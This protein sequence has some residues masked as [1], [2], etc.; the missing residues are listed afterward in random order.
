MEFSKKII[1]VTGGL[2]ILTLIEI[3]VLSLIGADLS[4]IATQ[5]TITTGGIFGASICFYLNK[6]KIE[7]LA[8]GKVKFAFTKLKLDLK[9]KNL[10]PEE[11]YAKVEE[12]LNEIFDM[13]DRRVD[14]LLEESI[15]E[16]IT[17]QDYY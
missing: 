14:S 7:N 15:N 13:Y 1:V 9:L 2:F 3:A 10:V 5:Q 16:E 12:E 8:K 17:K 4:Y 6:A 11:Q